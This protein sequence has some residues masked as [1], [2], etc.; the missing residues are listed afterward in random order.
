MFF[1]YRGQNQDGSGVLNAGNGLDHVQ[2]MLPALGVVGVSSYIAAGLQ[3]ITS[4]YL[5]ECNSIQ[6]VVYQTVV[7]QDGIAKI[8]QG[9][10]IDY[11]FTPVAWFW[12]IAAMISFLLP[13]LNWKRLKR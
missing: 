9:E 7:D 10:Y 1:L 4:G 5:I 11:N 2:Q 13:V 12:L 8:T 3:D 6:K